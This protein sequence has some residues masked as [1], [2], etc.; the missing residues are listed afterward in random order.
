M[1]TFKIIFFTIAGLCA[2]W[3]SA[4]GFIWLAN[5]AF[6]R[7][8]KYEC[9]K[10]AKWSKEYKETFFYSDYQKSMCNIK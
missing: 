3:Y 4:L 5:E 6:D 9:E 8:D 10:L 7:H 2:L 1:K